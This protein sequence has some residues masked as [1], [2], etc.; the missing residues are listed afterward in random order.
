L[1]PVTT[2]EYGWQ[3]TVLGSTILFFAM[4]GF[5]FISTISEEAINT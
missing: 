4:I 2:E 3:G 5:D 1:T